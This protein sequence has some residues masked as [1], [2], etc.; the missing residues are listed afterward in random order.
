VKCNFDQSGCSTL[1]HCGVSVLRIRGVVLLKMLHKSQQLL[2]RFEDKCQHANGDFFCGGLIVVV[3]GLCD[4]QPHNSTGESKTSK[5][6][7]SSLCLLLF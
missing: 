6:Q 4:N 2:I 1:L 7:F 3:T 5:Q